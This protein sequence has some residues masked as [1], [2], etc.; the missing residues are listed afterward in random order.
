MRS[1]YAEVVSGLRATIRLSRLRGQVRSARARL[2]TRIAAGLGLGLL[3]AAVFAGNIVTWLAQH[4][5]SSSP[6]F[7]YLVGGTSVSLV[8]ALGTV[9]DG[10]RLQGA[11]K[12]RIRL[13]ICIPVP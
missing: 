3:V 11:S 1:L 4:S 6:I 13:K 2:R 12:T 7:P 9:D 8:A 10:R 5:T